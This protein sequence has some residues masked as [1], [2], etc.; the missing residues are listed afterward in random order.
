MRIRTIMVLIA[1]VALS[2]TVCLLMPS[3][4]D[5][6]LNDEYLG[7]T[8]TSEH[9][10]NISGSPIVVAD[11]FRGGI[12]VR[13]GE[14]GHI[15]TTVEVHTSCKNSSVTESIEALD[16]ADVRFEQEGNKIRI[17]GHIDDYHNSNCTTSTSLI[18]YAPENS[19]LDL[20]TACGTISVLG[21]PSEVV[22]TSEFGVMDVNI[23]L[24]SFE[25]SAPQLT[26]TGRLVIRKGMILFDGLRKAANPGDRITVRG[27]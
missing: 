27:E 10:W 20:H 18:I 3:T 24:G 16:S 21:S 15:T 13:P 23:K 25:K 6:L 17:L 2:L 4:L 9:K 26:K 7:V 19:I 22:A 1:W 11:V 8:R 12:W 14:S 5:S